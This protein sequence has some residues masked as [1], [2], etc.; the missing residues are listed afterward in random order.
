[1]RALPTEYAR[2]SKLEP[3]RHTD[4]RELRGKGCPGQET[5]HDLKRTQ[6]PFTSA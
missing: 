5:G 6:G 1:M 3:D 2:Y 4:L